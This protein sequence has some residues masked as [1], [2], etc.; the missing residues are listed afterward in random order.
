[1]A[2][3]QKPPSNAQFPYTDVRLD[4]KLQT[5][6]REKDRDSESTRKSDHRHVARSNI[7]DILSDSDLD[8]SES[9][10]S[11]PV[12]EKSRSRS[13]TRSDFR[14][15]SRSPKLPF[16]HGDKDKWLAFIL[17]FT[18][19]AKNAH[20]SSHKR[21]RKLSSCLRDK[22][23]LYVKRQ[24]K[25]DRGS[26]RDLLRILHWRYGQK[27]PPATYRRQLSFLKQ[28]DE[29]V[30][31]FADSVYEL[32]LDAYPKHEGWSKSNIEKLAVDAFLR[33]VKDK[34]GAMFATRERPETLS[35]A[36]EAVTEVIQDHKALGRPAFG[37][38]QVAFRDESRSPSPNARNSNP[39]DKSLHNKMLE[40]LDKTEK[41][42]SLVEKAFTKGLDLLDKR[43]A[44]P[45]RSQSPTGACYNCDKVGHYARNCPSPKR[46]RSPTTSPTT[47]KGNV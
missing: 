31:D 16:F 34:T 30:D 15:R 32:A 42:M 12:R 20:W 41:V 47:G 6:V 33:G 10:E 4:P 36:V 27:Q 43:S 35:E 25:E 37:V 29:E 26:Y 44:S 46:V 14:R 7:E 45:V 5:K 22:A 8:L 23:L 3:Y 24:P 28:D 40:T 17:S 1:M 13:T 18:T 38:K 21:F 19:V 39:A 2:G 9:V 11:S